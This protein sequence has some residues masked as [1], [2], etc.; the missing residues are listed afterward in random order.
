MQKP[1]T[2]SLTLHNSS[3]PLETREVDVHRTGEPNLTQM[4]EIMKEWLPT[5]DN[6]DS[7]TF[8]NRR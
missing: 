5:I 2:F 8:A 3:G 1:E 6:G 7:I 4:F